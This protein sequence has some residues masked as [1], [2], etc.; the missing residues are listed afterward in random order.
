MKTRTGSCFLFSFSGKYMLSVVS[1]IIVCSSG[2]SEN[3]KHSDVFLSP[4]IILEDC[5]VNIFLI[6]LSWPEVVTS[7]Y[8]TTSEISFYLAV[9]RPVRI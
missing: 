4:T 1:V 3:K 9:K 2:H 8:I 6:S 5:I 7:S